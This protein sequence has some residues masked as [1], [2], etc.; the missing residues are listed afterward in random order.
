MKMLAALILATVLAPQA[1]AL[2][3]K[4]EIISTACGH[5]EVSV[6][7]TGGE[8]L[9]QNGDRTCWF[10]DFGQRGSV[11][12]VESVYPFANLDTYELAM[13][14]QTVTLIHDPAKQLARLTYAKPD[15]GMLTT[16]YDLKCEISR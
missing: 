7:I 13:K 4:T 16:K 1:Q 8:F 15:P 14:S 10:A 9:I 3:C 5:D 12:E 2:K 6:E 11:V